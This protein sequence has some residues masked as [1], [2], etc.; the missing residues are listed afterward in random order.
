MLIQNVECLETLHETY[1]YI[2]R[3][4][5][6]NFTFTCLAIEAKRVSARCWRDW[7]E[8]FGILLVCL[9]YERQC[10]TFWKLDGINLTNFF[11]SFYIV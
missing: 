9:K 4:E 5:T 7:G 1:C 10:W 6:Y 3:S 2:V 11:V 8:N